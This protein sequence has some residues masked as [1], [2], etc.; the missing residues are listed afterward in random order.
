MNLLDTLLWCILFADDIIL[1]DEAHKEVNVKLKSWRKKLEVKSF[2][3]SKIKSKHIEFN[4][5]SSRYSKTIIKIGDNI[6]YSK[7][8]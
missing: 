8:I 4:F 7:T 2:N 3:L 6:W 1:I 5:S